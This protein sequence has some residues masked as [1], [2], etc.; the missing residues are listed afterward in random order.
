MPTRTQRLTVAVLA[1]ALVALNAPAAAPAADYEARDYL[2]LTVGNSWTFRHEV[3]DYHGGIFDH[4]LRWPAYEQA[5]LDSGWAKG[6]LVTITVERTEEID[7]LTYYVLS[8]IPEGGW[9]PAPPHCPVGKKLRWKGSELMERTDTGEQSF[10]RFDGASRYTIP[11]THGD[12]EVTRRGGGGPPPRAPTIGFGFTGNDALD[13]LSEF[14]PEGWWGA[15]GVTFLAGYGLSYCSEHAQG[16]DYGVFKNKLSAVRAVLV[17]DTSD[18]R[19][20]QSGT[21]RTIEID[22]AARGGPPPEPPSSA[23]S[24][25]WGQ[26]KGSVSDR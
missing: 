23:S 9:P 10:F 21:P 8:D 25:S 2:S 24:S 14:E 3:N 26:V 20:G 15:R 7:G 19:R 13:W 12:D 4:S 16:P 18:G 17:E 5:I 11:L 22:D 1:A 6:S